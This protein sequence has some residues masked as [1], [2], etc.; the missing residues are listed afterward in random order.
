MLLKAAGLTIGT[1]VTAAAVNFL[2]TVGA[3]EAGRA[4]ARVT[5]SRCLCTGSTIEAW[6][7]RT[8]HGAHLTILSMEALGACARVVVHQILQR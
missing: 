7:I 8:G 3:H 2:L 6:L 5:F 1:G 4:A